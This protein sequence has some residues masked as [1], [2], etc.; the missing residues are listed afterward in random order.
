MKIHVV[1]NYD[2]MSREAADILA[3]IVKNKPD[4]VLGLATGDTPIGMYECLVR[5]YEAGELDF[6]AVRSVNLDEYYPISPDN[7]QSYRYFMNKHLFDK[8]NIDKANTN[9]PN[10]R[11]ED[12]DVFCREYENTI[13]KLG[14]MDVQ[15][16]GIGRNGHIGFNEPETE[17][18]PY[19]HLTELT[20]STI[21]A[22]ARF[23]ES[24]A[25]VPKHALTMG[26][27][28]I[29]K[30][31]NIVILASGV[32]KA[33]AVK[34]MLSGNISTLCPASLLCL[35]PSVTLICDKAAYSLV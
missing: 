25:D 18:K 9:V 4:C 35:H 14:G 19:T 34:T 32:E 15:V 16:L 26:I 7:D 6:S 3:D 10:G 24:E 11:A 31:R 21:E 12:A 20:E 13:N 33:E 1:E 2:E 28:S 22:N 30:A 27:R 17:L 23:F 5:M 8:V 29:F